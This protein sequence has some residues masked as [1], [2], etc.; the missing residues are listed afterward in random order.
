MAVAAGASLEVE[1]IGTE[2]AGLGSIE[3]N[4]VVHRSKAISIIEVRARPPEAALTSSVETI[5]SSLQPHMETKSVESLASSLHSH[6]ERIGTIEGRLAQL[7]RE[8]GGQ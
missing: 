4:G 2:P 5:A 3:V 7:H 8:A 1:R 6:M